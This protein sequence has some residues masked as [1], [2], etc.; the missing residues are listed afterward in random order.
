M[1]EYTDKVERQRILMQAEECGKGVRYIHANNGIIETAY[2]NG[3]V[4]YQETKTGKKWTVYA[5][6]S[7]GTIVERF[8][9][10][11]SDGS[12]YGK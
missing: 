12:H 1:T 7:Q 10:W 8:L 5:N 6:H 4:H 9:R 3:D 2:Q 11:V